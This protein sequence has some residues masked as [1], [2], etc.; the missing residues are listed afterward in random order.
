MA[1]IFTISTGDR[2]ISEPSIVCVSRLRSPELPIPISGFF[3]IL[4]SCGADFDPSKNLFVWL[5]D[6]LHACCGCSYTDVRIL[7]KQN[8]QNILFFEHFF[9]NSKKY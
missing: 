4:S 5:D 6:E 3:E 8:I 9:D 2:H 7:I 1:V